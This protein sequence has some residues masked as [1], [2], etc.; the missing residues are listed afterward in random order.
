M[1]NP[2]G[3]ARQGIN[4]FERHIRIIFIKWEKILY[5]GGVYKLICH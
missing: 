5:Q 4:P 3:L 1:G 2:G